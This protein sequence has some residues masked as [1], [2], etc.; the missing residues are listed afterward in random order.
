MKNPLAIENARIPVKT[1]EDSRIRQMTSEEQAAAE[2]RLNHLVNASIDP[3]KRLKLLYRFIDKMWHDGFG[4]AVVCKRGCAHCCNVSVYLTDYEAQYIAYQQ[5][6]DVN[7]DKEKAGDYTDQPCTFL[8][9]NEC[10]IYEDRPLACRVYGTFDSAD[11]CAD[12]TYPSHQI[13]A[14]GAPGDGGLDAANHVALFLMQ[15]SG[16]KYKDIRQY[17]PEVAK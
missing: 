16:F 5:R 7:L 2:K 15:C 9:D 13:I 4:N 6:I 1:I 3:A 11:Y 10:S 12:P 8:K 17:F 14:V